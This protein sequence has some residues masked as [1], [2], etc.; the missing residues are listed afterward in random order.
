MSRAYTYEEM[1]KMFLDN[2]AGIV[3][4]WETVEFP[5]G[6]REGGVAFSILTLLDGCG[7]TPG[8]D[9]IPSPHPEDE[10]YCKSIGEN[11]W[12]PKNLSDGGLHEQYCSEYK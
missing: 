7:G 12:V 1:R 11:F 10:D 5:G 3:K 9:L 6:S 8:F 2:V 4:Y